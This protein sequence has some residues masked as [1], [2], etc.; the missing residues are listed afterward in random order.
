MAITDIILT[1][2]ETYSANIDGTVWWGITPPTRFY[3][4]VMAAIAAGVPVGAPPPPVIAIP[5][6]SFP[7]LLIGLVTEGWISESDGEGWLVGTLPAA[8]LALIATLPTNQQFAAK[9][10]ATRPSE[11][12]RSDPLVNA[13]GTA[14]GKTSIELDEFFITYSSV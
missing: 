9:A 12:I 6:L 8:V 1:A 3:E 2:P 4:N 13:L 10:R 14:E 11:I 5:N 7:Q